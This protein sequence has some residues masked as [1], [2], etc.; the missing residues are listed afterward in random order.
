MMKEK[1]VA[2]AEE[3]A[4][5]VIAADMAE[6]AA[7]VVHLAVAI[8]DAA[9]LVAAAVREAADATTGN[10]LWLAFALH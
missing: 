7:I 6:I 3:T 2:I 4:E 10:R 1:V 5:I 9:V 8:A